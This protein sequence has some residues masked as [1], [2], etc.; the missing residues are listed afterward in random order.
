MQV[1]VEDLAKRFHPDDAVP[2]GLL[3][4]ATSNLNRMSIAYASVNALSASIAALT[5]TGGPEVKETVKFVDM[6]DKFFD[7]LNV[8]NFTTAY[9]KQ[10]VFQWPYRSATGKGASECHLRGRR[11][12]DPED[13][14]QPCTSFL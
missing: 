13:I 11:Y 3:T 8:N 14:P 5:S 12:K 10:K 4:P 9:N 1:E 6:F 2:A 7:S